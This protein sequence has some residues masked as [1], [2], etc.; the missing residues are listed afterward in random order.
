MLVVNR[1]DIVDAD[2]HRASTLASDTR[3]QADLRTAIEAG[4]DV[5]F[6]HDVELLF[7]TLQSALWDRVSTTTT[8]T[9]SLLRQTEA[10]LQ[11]E[12]LKALFDPIAIYCQR[13]L[14]TLTAEDGGKT[15]EGAKV[16]G[17]ATVAEAARLTLFDRST[18]AQVERKL[19]RIHRAQAAVGCL[20]AL[21]CAR[22]RRWLAWCS[23]MERQAEVTDSPDDGV[24]AVRSCRSKTSFFFDED[25]ADRRRARS[26]AMM[27]N[28]MHTSG[29]PTLQAAMTVDAA[30]PVQSVQSAQGGEARE[31]GWTVFPDS[32][33]PVAVAAAPLHTSN[34]LAQNRHDDSSIT[35]SRQISTVRDARGESVSI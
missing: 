24:A 25:D 12:H 34:P 14:Y 23:A 32:P 3:W 1:G 35:R 26:M 9:H 7:G 10:P 33:N 27:E 16:D 15:E 29:N 22:A 20:R 17:G 19:A 6:L 5:I 2:G 18:L 21:V 4:L 8:N 30:V 28:P 31:R 11:A 13:S